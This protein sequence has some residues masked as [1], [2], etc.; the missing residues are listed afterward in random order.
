MK[1]NIFILLVFCFSITICYSQSNNYTEFNKNAILDSITRLNKQIDEIEYKFK[2][3]DSTFKS[4]T[5]R[6]NKTID[7][8]IESI[9]DIKLSDTLKS[10]ESTLIKQ[11]FLVDGFSYILAGLTILITTLSIV[12]YIILTKSNRQTEQ[13]ILRSNIATDRL[14]DR[15][16]Y[17]DDKI[18]NQLDKKF[19]DYELNKEAT[20]FKELFRDLRSK[21]PYLKKI[22][23]EKLSVLKLEK[24]NVSHINDLIDIILLKTLNEEEKTAIIEV[25]IH[26]N[27]HQVENFLKTWCD[28]KKDNKGLKDLL[29]KYYIENGFGNFLNPITTFILDF[30]SPHIEFNDI[31]TNLSSHIEYIYL[32]I[33]H[34]PLIKSLNNYS[35]SKVKNFINEYATGWSL[36]KEKIEHS[37]LFFKIK[38]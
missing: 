27:D 17:F 9:G 11:N 19:D 14:N 10:A 1:K 20:E 23:I 5:T 4:E 31:I 24:I 22:A 35:K 36:D 37:L 30:S 29:L 8:T 33:N 16:D 28:V 15:M 25:L 13:A 26:K 18:N 2:L 12:F 32:L 6:L 21:F 38:R 7:S 34:E 3:A